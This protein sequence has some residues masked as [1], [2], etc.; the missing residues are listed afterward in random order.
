MSVT[1]SSANVEPPPLLFGQRSPSP[2]S[3]SSPPQSP[4][5]L[6]HT[7]TPVSSPP[8][9]PI[10]DVD[11]STSTTMPPPEGQNHDREDAVMEDPEGLTNGHME[12]NTNN[13]NPPTTNV[14][15]EIAAVEDDA[16]DTTPD[17]GQGLVLPNGSADPQ[18]AI[19]NTSSSPAPNGITREEPGSNEQPPAAPIAENPPQTENVPPIEPHPS[20][21][22]SSQ[23]PPPPIEPIRSDPDSSD[24]DDGGQPWHPI[25]EDTSSPDETELKEIE[26]AGEVS[27]LDHDHW[28]QKAFQ[29]LDEP[30]YTPGAS[31][32]IEWIIENYNGTRE[33]PNKELVMKSQS[34]NIGG[35]DW[36]IKFYPKGN[37]SDYLSVYVECLSVE[38]KGT[39]KEE[40]KGNSPKHDEQ[41]STVD[42]AMRTDPSERDVES[43]HAPLPLLDA[44]SLPKRKS[45]AAQV[46]VVLYNPSE[47]RVNY[48]R[49][50][51]HRF[52]TGSPDWGWTRF[53][54]P[55]YDIP[56]RQRGQRQA[57]LRNDK[58]AF[59]GYIRVINDDTNCLWEHHSRDNPWDSFS[60]T[61]LQSLTLGE[62][63]ST[64]GGNMISAIASWML[65]KPFRRFLYHFKVPDPE[66]EPFARPK[67][68]ISALQKVL[69]MLRTQANP[70]AGPVALDDVLDALEWYGI[71]DRL[72]KLDVIEVWEVLRHKVEDE[73][74]DTPSANALDDLFGLKKDYVSGIPNY[75]VPVVT[76][77]SMQEAVNKATDLLHPTQHLPQLLTIELDRQDFDMATRSY[78]KLLN[79]VTLDDYIH[80]RGVTYTLYGFVVH[81]QTLQSYLYHPVIRPEGPGFKW[82][83][84]TDGKE[85]NMVKCLT[86]RQAIDFHEGKSGSEKVIGNDAVAYIVMYVREDVTE[87]AFGCQPESEQWVVPDWLIKEVEKMQ[88]SNIPPLIPPPPPAEDPQSNAEKKIKSTEE[89][90]PPKVHEFQVIDSRAFLQHEGPGIFDAYDSKWQPGNS[91]LVHTVQLT[92]TDGCKEIRDKLASV[93]RDIKDSRQIKFWFLD[94]MRGT[95]A[96]PNLLG[97]GQ[98]EYSSGSTDH[99]ADQSKV[100]SLSDYQESWAAYRIWIHVLDFADLP[101]LPEEEPKAPEPA[102]EPAP[103]AS[104]STSEATPLNDNTTSTDVPVPAPVQT[105]LVPESEDTPMSEPDEPEPQQS[106]E[107]QR[108][109]NQALVTQDNAEP[110]DTAMV[111][112]EVE[113][114]VESTPVADP[115][116]VD[117]VI[118]SATAPADTEMSGTQ[119]ELPPPPPPPLVDLQPE[120]VPPPVH[121]QQ[122]VPPPPPPAPVHTIPDEI[123]FFLKF[124]D[125]EAQ[126][127]ESKGSHITLKSDKVDQKVLS[128]LGFPSD[129]KIELFEEED[130][131]TTHPI[132]N[133]RTFAQNDLHNTAVIIATLPLTEEQRNSLA[134]RAAFADPQPYLAFRAHARNFPT[135]I[136]GHFTV[137]HFSSQYYKGE[138]K[139]GHRHGHG[140]RF[141]HSG[142]TY[143]GSF[144]L[145]QRHGHGLYTFQNGD[146]YDGDWV[147]NQQHGTGT[148]VEAAT[149][150]TYVGGWKNDKKFGE[151]V[152]HWKNAQE[153][154]RLC[155]ICWEEGADTAFY[156]CGHVVACLQCARRVDSCP[157]C[158]KRVL[159]AMKLYYVA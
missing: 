149:G 112:V 129:K 4:N 110:N 83:S 132:R 91:D 5:H 147:A 73:L 57:L 80:V 60:M 37:D 133:R 96:R 49:T 61:G 143:T 33:N 48:V 50:C 87:F 88:T 157:V 23:P 55:Y 2:P 156:D 153:T 158:R 142:A 111:E 41:M 99:Y 27:A 43:Q 72:D 146:T 126:T 86:K 105:E 134:A 10:E 145:S 26:E 106:S 108:L 155:R 152:T 64:P 93:V 71:H 39:K 116:A 63:A 21:D 94:A 22:A 138:I 118:P 35:Y 151:G 66:K 67:P 30:E 141:Y 38:E 114:A 45:I 84:Y 8:P 19:D 59:T 7:Q 14:A 65:F 144:R 68:L 159:S 28:E 117:V 78:V 109:E 1:A 16:M 3:F 12:T 130:L 42:D 136:T 47:P 75:R 107:T 69:Y 82:Y 53:H 54:G 121:F 70:G 29:P 97:T 125:A 24:D 58:L 154:E 90:V 44:K 131:T 113:V 11:M 98:I 76:V 32:R 34:V 20:L 102:P 6:H 103:E 95:V 85:E 36:Q 46:S 104:A 62:G 101:E 120:P 81:K 127:L 77:N 31:G 89:I 115:P 148:F 124:F 13:R 137:N 135:K 17:N 139:N 52:C 56:H 128:L 150:N 100:W 51:L 123:Y 122:N 9:Q 18:E 79:K 15:V 25:Q 92:S 74:R 40:A 119:D 140:T